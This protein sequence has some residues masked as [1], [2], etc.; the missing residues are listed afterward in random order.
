MRTI[1]IKLEDKHF[2]NNWQDLG[3]EIGVKG[4]QLRKFNNPSDYSPAEIVLRKI[5]TLKPD[6]L[7]TD[8]KHTLGELKLEPGLADAIANVL[9]DLKGKHL[10]MKRSENE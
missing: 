7:L 2:V 10:L 4:T 5:E 8:M 3:I 6:L 9:K 1:C